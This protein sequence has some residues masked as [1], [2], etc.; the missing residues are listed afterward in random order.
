MAK[1][2]RRDPTQAKGA[3]TKRIDSSVISSPEVGAHSG[4]KRLSLRSYLLMNGVFIAFCILQLLFIR[5]TLNEVKGLYFF[6]GLL[7]VGFA[8]VSVY[9]YIYDRIA[10]TDKDE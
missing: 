1:T 8:V 4:Q 10:S 7:I 2:K 3:S 9:D 5:I 6:F